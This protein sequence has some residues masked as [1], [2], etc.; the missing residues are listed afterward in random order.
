MGRPDARHPDTRRG[1]GGPNH[2]SR[3]PAACQHSG[4]GASRPAPRWPSPRRRRRADRIDRRPDGSPGVAIICDR[5]AGGAPRAGGARPRSGRDRRTDRGHQWQRRSCRSAR[6]RRPTR[7]DDSRSLPYGRGRRAS[8]AA[9]RATPRCIHWPQ[10]CGRKWSSDFGTRDAETG[11]L[12]AEVPQEGGKRPGGS[13][14]MAPGRPEGSRQP[15]SGGL[16][17]PSRRRR[18]PRR[19]PATKSR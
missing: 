11:Q 19:P 12:A 10:Q 2:R 9:P 8:S 18:P 16:R 3:R 5:A 13:A 1:L 6:R 7:G 17:M 14:S 4:P 15:G